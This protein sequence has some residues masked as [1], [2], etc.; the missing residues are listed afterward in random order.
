[1]GHQSL[2]LDVKIVTER[3]LTTA[4]KSVDF[5][6]DVKRPNHNEPRLAALNG[7]RPQLFGDIDPETDR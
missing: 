7:T 1:M 5:G 2:V 6:T 3:M 4:P